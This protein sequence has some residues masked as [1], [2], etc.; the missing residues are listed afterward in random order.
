MAFMETF[1]KAHVRAKKTNKSKKCKRRE[2]DSGSS[3]GSK[4]RTG[5]NDTG[6]CVDKHFNIEKPVGSLYMSTDPCPI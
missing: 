3:F 4:K 2:N 6:F 5:C 1:F